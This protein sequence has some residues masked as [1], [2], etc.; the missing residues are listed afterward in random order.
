MI[1]MFHSLFPTLNLEQQKAAKFRRRNIKPSEGILV[2][3]NGSPYRLNVLTSVLLLRLLFLK[4][5]AR[6]RQNILQQVTLLENIVKI[7]FH[8]HTPYKTHFSW[9]ILC[10]PLSYGTVNLFLLLKIL[11]RSKDILY[12]Q[13]PENHVMFLKQFLRKKVKEKVFFL[14]MMT[15]V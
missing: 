3:R 1:T 14:Y 2:S 12:S 5:H 11:S 6:A 15:V 7:S 9:V 8:V 13:K 4:K 10:L